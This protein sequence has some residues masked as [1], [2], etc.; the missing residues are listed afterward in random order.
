M[1]SLNEVL[2]IEVDNDALEVTLKQNLSLPEELKLED[3]TLFLEEHGIVYGISKET[4]EKIV[5]KEISLPVTVAQGEKPKHGIDACLW[6]V[7]EGFKGDSTE[8]TP[9]DDDKNLKQVINI[10]SVTAGTIVGKKINPTPE[11]KGVSVYGEEIKARPGK[12]LKLRPGK[13][14]RISDGGMEIISMIDG[15]VSVEPKVVH[16]YPIFE[17]NGNL[18]LNVGNIDFVGNVNI[19]GNVPSGFEIKARGDIRVHGSV[20]SAELVSGGS[21]YI[22]QGVV[23]QGKGLIDAQGEIKTSFLNQANIRA[24]GDIHVSKSIL[25]SKVETQGRLFCNQGKGNIVGGSI[26]AGVE[27]VVNELGNHMST[28]TELYIGL[29]ESIVT[30]EKKYKIQLKEARDDVQKLGVLLKRIVTKEAEGTLNAQEKIMKL[31]I[32]NSLFESNK[33]MQ[34]A[35][36]QLGELEEFFASQ[37][38]VKVKIQRTIYPNTVLNFGKYKRKIISKHDHVL[39]RIEKSEIKFETL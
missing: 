31:R 28:P 1:D 13:N 11:E 6:T 17:V 19:R 15:Q 21:I 32:R 4:L 7:L 23:A 27:I 9:G 10:P 22:H 30:A 29:S 26:S 25:H 8:V 33:L 37:E 2:L 5:S 34:E 35:S 36:E 24:K 14:T 39:F 12:D 16:V 3:L 20:E 18:D 38:D